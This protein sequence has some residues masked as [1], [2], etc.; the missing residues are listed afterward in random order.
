M[1]EFERPPQTKAD[2]AYQ[3]IRSQVLSG[4]LPPGSVLDQ[5]AIARSVGMSTTPVREALRRLE[6][7]ELIV[8]SAHRDARVSSLSHATLIDLFETR[9]SLD[10]L[11]A[12][13]AAS[14]AT[15]AELAALEKLTRRKPRS[16][17]AEAELNQ[18]FHQGLYGASHNKVLIGILDSLWNRTERYRGALIASEP[19]FHVDYDEHEAVL[20]ALARRDAVAAGE[21]MR[22]HVE[23]TLHRVQ[24]VIAD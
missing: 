18:A 1:S 20:D 16:A 17:K 19:G 15:D 5:A 2:A 12:T 21:L 7:E 23:S 11:A 9:L 8:M 10:P 14:R 24:M 22:K 6:S 13:L 4:A 3:Y